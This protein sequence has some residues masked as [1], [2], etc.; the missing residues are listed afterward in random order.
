MGFIGEKQKKILLN[1]LPKSLV[2]NLKRQQLKKRAPIEYQEWINGKRDGA[3]PHLYKQKLLRDLAKQNQL[4]ILVETGTFLG[5]MM[6]AQAPHFEKLYSIELDADLFTAATRR[7]SKQ[8]KI[9]IVHGDSG[10]M[11]KHVV[12]EI[13]KPAL[14]WLDG[15]YSGGF[16]AKGAK[17]CPIYDELETIF[18][19]ELPHVILVDDARCFVGASDYPTVT[20]LTQFILAKRPRAKVKVENDIIAIEQLG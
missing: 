3:A 2:F 11:L 19:S 13:D 20:E 12:L 14:F 4:K 1:F 17:D 9:K 16:T 5:L 6:E 15:H 18:K 7:F 8:P 10:E